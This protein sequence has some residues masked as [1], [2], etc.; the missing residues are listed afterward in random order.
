MIKNRLV[1]VKIEDRIHLKMY[2]LMWSKKNSLDKGPI[3]FKLIDEK[4]IRYIIRNIVS[5]IRE[6]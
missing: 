1:R 3:V 5:E 4:S 2:S 6:G